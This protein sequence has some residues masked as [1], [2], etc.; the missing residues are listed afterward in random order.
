MNRR[1]IL[2][3]AAASFVFPAIGLARSAE[4]FEAVL[5]RE[6]PRLQ[7]R[8]NVPGVA[9]ALIHRNGAPRILPFGARDAVSGAPVGP[10]TLFQVGSISKFVT[11]ICVMR[12]AEQ[13]RLALDAPINRYLT[14]WQLSSDRYAVDRVTLRRLLSHSAGLSVHGYFPGYRYPG[15]VPGLLESVRGDTSPDEAVRIATPPGTSFS[16]SGGGYSLIQLAIED[17]LRASYP[18]LAAT[19]LFKP[20]G[21]R[22]SSFRPGFILD[23]NAALPHDLGGRP[24]PVRVLPQLAAA[25][26]SI[27]AGDLAMLVQSALEPAMRGHGLLTSAAAALLATPIAPVGPVPARRGSN[28]TMLAPETFP[29]P[30]AFRYGPGA[31]IATRADGC[32]IVGHGGSNAGWKA[33]VQYN[34]ETGEGIVVL[35]NAEPGN[36]LVFR[37]L[38]LWR[39]RLDAATGSTSTC[40]PFEQATSF[41]TAAF[42]RGGAQ[43]AMGA[44]TQIVTEGPDRWLFSDRTADEAASQLLEF[45]PI[46]GRSQQELEGAAIDLASA[47]AG[48]FP[49][50]SFAQATA[51]A[52]FARSGRRAEAEAAI[53]RARR[54][55]PDEDARRILTIAERSLSGSRAQ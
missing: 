6:V 13:G 2:G 8:Y 16:Y 10:D 18:D 27:S 17:R 25:G 39:E 5:D 47:N 46:E 28:Q 49:D 53:S 51:A 11:A 54:G 41:V 1:E 7:E 40:P 42:G 30:A 20:L 12:L 29:D 26:L 15:P 31:A 44:L 21:L 4:T 35:T 32:R 33:S 24:M 34:L 23:R 37:I 22:R 45:G 43:A 9:I 38:S 55:T 48:L 36:G 3:A 52:A 14:R 50:S 19:L